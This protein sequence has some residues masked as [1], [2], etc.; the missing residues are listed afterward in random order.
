MVTSDQTVDL[1]ERAWAWVLTQV[2][3]DEVGLWIPERVA[4]DGTPS[5]LEDPY[6]DSIYLGLGSLALTL[7]EIARYRAWTE[8]EQLLADRI[9]QRLTGASDTSLTPGLSLG[10]GSNLTSMHI[11]GAQP[12]GLDRL[13]A[14]VTPDGWVDMD[15]D[16]T[17]PCYD[18][19]M[20]TAGVALV[21]TYLDRNNAT[22]GFP[23][24]TWINYAIDVLLAKASSTPTGLEWPMYAGDKWGM[25]PNYSHGTAG[26][27]AALAICGSYVGRADAIDAAMAGA[28]HVV[29]IGDRSNNGFRVPTVVPKGDR[30]IEDF[31]YG[32]CHGPTG[33][34]Y[35]FGAL[36]YA[37]IGEIDGIACDEWIIRCLN[38]IQ[39]SGVP[40][41][42]RPGFWDND[43]RCC[44]TAGVLDF[45]LDVL[46]RDPARADVAYID[47][48]VSALVDRAV[49]DGPHSYWRFT[50]HRAEQ[51]LLDPGVGW[52]QGA[53]GIAAT[54]LR[55]S[56]VRADPTGASRQVRPEAWWM[57][58]MD[59]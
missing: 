15:G 49:H 26:V 8:E 41:G 47:T 2:R 59:V 17:L 51:Q 9:L 20:G 31:A 14:L 5:P 53:A 57:C 12:V 7:D 33:T 48:L 13:V 11:L 44:G 55:Y 32:W 23:A 10:V 35:L 28:R 22:G 54:L 42:I 37:G 16:E 25:M 3:A 43:G 4:A 45:A 50:E 30:D 34:A 6:R 46:Q 21:L 52:M 19:L 58:T 29:T 39:N 27:A 18:L 36:A 1:A 40:Q 56:R 38:A 24:T